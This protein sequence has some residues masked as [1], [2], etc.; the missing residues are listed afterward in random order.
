MF[1]S[2]C[3]EITGGRVGDGISLALAAYGIGTGVSTVCYE[4]VQLR[5][6]G[7]EGVTGAP[8]GRPCSLTFLGKW[9]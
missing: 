2:A 1:L 9:I 3:V 6:K 5:W 4:V 7:W 8:P